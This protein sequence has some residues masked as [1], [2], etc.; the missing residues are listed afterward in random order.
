M[1]MEI[2]DRFIK[3]KF[4]YY[5]FVNKIKIVNIQFKYSNK[6]GEVMKFKA[7]NL[8]SMK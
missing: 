6:L 5:L 8:K 3:L 7:N 4:I 1:I 2:V